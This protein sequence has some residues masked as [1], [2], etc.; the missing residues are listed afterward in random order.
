MSTNTPS[1]Y[2]GFNIATGDRILFFLIVGIIALV[3][4]SF[5]VGATAIATGAGCAAVA[6]EWFR[7]TTGERNFD[8]PLIGIVLA[9]GILPPFLTFAVGAG[10][11]AAVALLTAGFLLLMG[12]KEN[13]LLVKTALGLAVIG[14]AGVCFVWMRAQ[15]DHGTALVAWLLMVVAATEISGG[16]YKRNIS[17]SGALLPAEPREPPAGLLLSMVC[18]LIAGVIAGIGYGA[19]NI[20]WIALASLGVAIVVLGANFLTQRVR[21]SVPSAPSGSLFLGRGPVIENVDGLICAS[22][23]AG[24]IM[25]VAGNLFT[26]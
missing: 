5:G 20:Y 2:K 22:L 6:Y 19:G 17:P 7:M 13:G 23:I 4:F 25:M 9:A 16:Y 24:G 3:F 21:E 26:W 14:L 8:E 1:A 11:G 15:P 18:G 10:G 12:P